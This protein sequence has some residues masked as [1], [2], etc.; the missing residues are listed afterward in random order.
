MSQEIKLVEIGNKKLVEEEKKSKYS[1]LSQLNEVDD[2]RSDFSGQSS[3]DLS[4][5]SRQGVDKVRERDGEKLHYITMR[6][7]EA[8]F[9]EIILKP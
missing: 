1:G 8:R 4:A 5:V 9:L 6:A 2:E 3:V 7:F